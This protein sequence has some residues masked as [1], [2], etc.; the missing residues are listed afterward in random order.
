ME[1]LPVFRP[2][3]HMLCLM[4]LGVMAQ[5]PL[6]IIAVV[7]DT[8]QGYAGVCKFLSEILDLRALCDTR[9]DCQHNTF[10]CLSYCQ[11]ITRRGEGWRINEYNIEMRLESLQLSPS[12]FPIRAP[13]P[14]QVIRVKTMTSRESRPT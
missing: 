2:S 11:L 14:K 6:R 3:G 9:A 7:H 10:H 12:I 1:L 5:Q 4:D 8:E 13:P